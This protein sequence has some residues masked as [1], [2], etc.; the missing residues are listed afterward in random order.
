MPIAQDHSFGG[1]Y[2]EV[3]E[4]DGGKKGRKGK[5]KKNKGGKKM[6]K[7]IK[8]GM[9]GLGALM[10]LFQHF[11]LKKLAFFSFF[12]FILSKISFILASLVALKQFFHNSGGHSR[13][14]K[15]EVIHIPIKKKHP[16]EDWDESKIVPITFPSNSFKAS[17]TSPFKFTY[18][19][20]DSFLGS[21]ENF[22]DEFVPKVNNAGEYNFGNSGSSFDE[23]DKSDKNSY[24][25]KSYYI[26]HVHSPFV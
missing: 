23:F 2:Y 16:L 7:H 4:D 20:H 22:S 15:L 25:E 12:S 10:L 21:E 1:G 8:H 24:D 13:D 14:N 26:N 19:S 11:A 18:S 6:Y 5:K 17:T 3:E 9:Q